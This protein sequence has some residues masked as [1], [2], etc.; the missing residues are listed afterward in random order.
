VAGFR[1]GL[2]EIECTPRT[3]LPLQGNFRDDYAARGV[4]DPLR[5]KALVVEAGGVTV[6]IAAVDVCLLDASNVAT[7]REA[8]SRS[9]GIPTGNVMVC[10]THTHSGPALT[11]LGIMPKCAEG[12]I[13]AFLVRAAGAVEA[14]YRALA[15][16]DLSVGKAREERVSF[17]RRLKCA[18]GRTHMN[19]EGLDPAFVL[20]PLG[21]TDPELQVLAVDRGGRPSGALVNF[22][23]HPA[24]LAGDNWLYSAD[25]PGYLAEALGR[26]E[27]GGFVSIFANGCCGNVNHIDYTDRLQGRGYQMTQRIGFM[28]ATAAH[29]A[30]GSREGV[31]GVELRVA[32]RRVELER[33][34]VGEADFE[35]ARKVMA[36]VD[37]GTVAGQVDGLPEEFYAH[38]LV[39]MHDAQ[40]RRDTAEVMCIRLG[41][42]AVVGLPSEIFCELGMEVKRRSPARRTIV[43]ELANDWFGYIP[44]R[45]SFEQGGYEPSTGSTEYVPGTG[46]KLADAA[47]GALRDLFG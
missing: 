38:M 36:G 17:N 28:L 6:A 20:A 24:V 27:G 4:H 9:T 26:L 2:G 13:R 43:C 10:A 34:R 16:A 30:L 39:R 5:A 8:A 42:A 40:E 46:E 18:D 29:E 23:L 15:P 32:S 35:R 22:G 45:V 47:V 14:A 3:G 11:D 7:F 1:A 33:L 37:V 44:T 12:D 19:W 31:R 21:S 41:D 25:Y